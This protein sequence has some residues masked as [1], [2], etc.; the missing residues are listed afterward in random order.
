[1]LG[2][3]YYSSLVI[4]FSLLSLYSVTCGSFTGYDKIEKK[5]GEKGIFSVQLYSYLLVIA[6]QSIG[7]GYFICWLLLFHPLEMVISSAEYGYF[8][9]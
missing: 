8:I 3:F 5:E 6:I 9:C 1:M 2:I 4:Y 7:Y